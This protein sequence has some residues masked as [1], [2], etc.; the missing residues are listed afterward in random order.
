MQHA[1]KMEHTTVT[2]A[3]EDT[4][5]RVKGQADHHVAATAACIET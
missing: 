4:K 1:S 5:Q 2:S 3:K